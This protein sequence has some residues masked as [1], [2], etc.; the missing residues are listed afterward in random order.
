VIFV[1]D[2]IGKPGIK[3]GLMQPW[4]DDMTSLAALPNVSCKISGATT[5]ADHVTWKEAEI[6]PYLRHAITVFGF[7]RIMFGG[8]WPVC[9]LAT[10]YQRWV[11]LVDHAVQGESLSNKRKL[12]RDNALKFYRIS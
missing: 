5:E 10:T 9:E 6:L 8:D 2:H 7:D 1:L 4:Q 12:F 3:A 11:N